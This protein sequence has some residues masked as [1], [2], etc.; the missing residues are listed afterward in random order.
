MFK[1][2]ILF[3]AGLVASALLIAVPLFFIKIRQFKAMGEHG[4]AVAA[5]MPPTTVTAADVKPDT[6]GDSLTAPG[7]LEAVQGVTVAA[8]TAGKVVKIAFEPG[9]VV[10]AGALLVQLDTSTEEAQLQAAE[11]TAALA[12]LNLERARELRQSNTNSQADLDAAEAQA[13][14]AQAQADSIRAVIAKKTIRAPFAGRLGIRYVNLGQI[15]REGDAI[16]ALQTLDPIY[17]NF[18][19]PQQRLAQLA[20][21]TK[22]R[23]TSDAAP[24][25]VFTGEINAINPEIDAATRNVRVQATLT[26]TGEMLRP[27]M[28]ANVEIVLPTQAR[29]LTIPVTAILYAPYGDSVFVIDEKKDEQSGKLQQVLRQQFIRVGGS[30]GDFVNVLDGLKPG[31]RV[32]SSGVFK[33][34]PGTPVVIDNSLAPDA[35]LHPKPKNT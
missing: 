26:N 30:R 11:A 34:R 29:V 28:F 14:Q 25:Q 5:A 21:G 18:S 10:A 27:G 13:K 17:V 20:R 1:K 24:G 35:Q 22:V 12:R 16:S 8:E 2:P 9:A 7:S 33:L 3:F 23:V 15:L 32:V 19:L 4:A 31:E 6:W